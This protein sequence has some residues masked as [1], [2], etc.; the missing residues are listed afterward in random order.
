MIAGAHAVWP[1]VRQE[2]PGFDSVRIYIGLAGEA[3]GA[4]GLTGAAQML[5]RSKKA[6]H[7]RSCVVMERTAGTSNLR[8][9]AVVK[10]DR[11]VVHP[12]LKVAVAGGLH[13]LALV[14]L[15]EG[16]ACL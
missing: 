6:G 12:L 10:V 15:G 5:D 9:V 3:V 8:E 11:L 4:V 13:R 1:Q 16:L 2:I 7:S 14:A